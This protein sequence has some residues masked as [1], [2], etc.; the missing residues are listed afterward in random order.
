MSKAPN[1]SVAKKEHVFTRRTGMKQYLSGN[2]IPILQASRAQIILK[3]A[4]AVIDAVE[5]SMALPAEW[6]WLVNKQ[7]VYPEN[8]G[9]KKKVTTNSQKTSSFLVTRF[10][11]LIRL[12]ALTR[13]AQQFRPRFTMG[14][15]DS[16]QISPNKYSGKKACGDRSPKVVLFEYSTV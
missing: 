2:D 14:E 6:I 4:V 11:L 12:A 1:R 5:Q 10:C 7:N 15:K 13:L 16:L 3:A 8:F 9:L